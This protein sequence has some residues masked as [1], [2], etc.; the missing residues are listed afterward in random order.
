M[1]L[2]KTQIM[3]RHFVI[4]LIICG[5]LLSCEQ[6][7]ADKSIVRSRK[8]KES[9]IEAYKKVSLFRT[10]NNIPGLAVAVSINNQLVWADGF[11]YSNFELK[12]KASPSH[13]FRIG[14]VSE[15]IT[16]VTA[17]K[18]Y[19]Q[20]KLKIDQPIAELLPGL[21]QKPANYT[22]HQ[23]GVH[24]SGIR[25]EKTA[26]GKGNTNSLEKLIPSFINDDLLYEPDTYV[27]H[28]EL[29]YDLIGYAIQKITNEPFLKVEKKIL[30]DTLK[31]SNTIPD[32][33]YL[34]IENKSSTYNYDYLARP[35]SSGQIDLR[36]KEASA[37]YLSSVL[38]LVRLGNTLLYPGFLKQETIDLITKPYTLKSGQISPFGFGLIVNKDTEGQTFYGQRGSLSGGCTS[39]L[40]YPDD[41]LVIA[42]SS[43]IENGSWEL[44]V[45]DV[46][47]IFQG[48]LHPDR[49]AKT[50]EKGQESPKSK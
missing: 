15:L 39:L 36:G 46:A 2:M 13:K 4:L 16:A 25:D 26:A 23:L 35:I 50:Q 17:T 40:I 12:A 32:N 33:P 18:L 19:E 8:Y 49:K 31:L 10:I 24:S 20:G 21:S 14:Q 5:S 22:I 7:P 3:P 9:V 28:S 41:K 45:F 44:P 11:G 43:N 47:S 30:L 34:I 6:K 48:Q 27:L 29:G 38:D 1:K 42:I 37:G